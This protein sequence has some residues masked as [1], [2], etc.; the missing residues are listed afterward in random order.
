MKAGKTLKLLLAASLAVGAMA[1]APAQVRAADPVVTVIDGAEMT[2]VQQSSSG[3]SSGSWGA[4]WSEHE[5]AIVVHVPV[6]LPAGMR[7]TISFDYSVSSDRPL[8]VG[9]DTR[10][11]FLRCP[12][13]AV[14]ASARAIGSPSPSTSPG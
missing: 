6:A 12:K 3:Y 14:R 9:V 2:V 7:S 8:M 4:V 1:F 13:V 5:Q 11:S 10:N